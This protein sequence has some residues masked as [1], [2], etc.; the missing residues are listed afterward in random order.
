MDLLAISIGNTR[1]KWGVFTQGTLDRHGAIEAR[2]APASAML[3]QVLLV[4]S[5]LV[6]QPATIAIASVNPAVSDPLVRD[7]RAHRGETLGEVLRLRHELPIRI[8]HSL[9]D[10]TTVGQDR[11]INALGA[12]SRLNQACVVVDAGT[13][14]TV[15]FVDGQ[16]TFHGGAI[17]PG[18]NM[19]LRA[20]HEQTAALPL[21]RYEPS[22]AR[23]DHPGAGPFGKET[24]GA[25]LLGVR[26]AVVGMVRLLVERYA[27]FYGGYPAVIATGGDA[28]ALFEGDEIV[29][30]L[31]PELPLLG[32]HACW[33]AA[34]ELE[35]GDDSLADD[36]ETGA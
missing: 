13:A 7:L 21:V 17:G 1:L 22:D 31:V 15:D 27:E 4:Q 10:D 12:F 18:L 26:A 16:G 30:R 35:D 14:V 6:D 33:K 24:K 25:M 36:D 34:L 20:L 2:L 29:E 23:E 9:V 5:Q 19:M 32:I 8:R 3:A 11:L 28:R